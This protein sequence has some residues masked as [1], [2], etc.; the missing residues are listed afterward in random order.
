MALYVSLYVITRERAE[1]R[2]EKE[3][4]VTQSIG[5]TGESHDDGSLL[6]KQGKEIRV[7]TAA[8]FVPDKK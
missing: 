3:Q 8:A 5:S 7:T 1:E 6:R 4:R 2:E